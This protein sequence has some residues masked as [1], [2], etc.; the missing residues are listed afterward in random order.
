MHDTLLPAIKGYIDVLPTQNISKIACGW[1]LNIDSDTPLKMRAIDNDK[2]IPIEYK[3]RPDVASFYKVADHLPVGWSISYDKHTA[4]TLQAWVGEQWQSVFYL[5][6]TNIERNELKEQVQSW[7]VFDTLL[8]RK[9]PHPTDIFSIIETNYPYASF[10]HLRMA[11]ERQS[12]GTIADIYLQFQKLTGE[13][14][15]CIE[16]LRRFELQTEKEMT[17]PIQTNIQKIK[18]GDILVSDMYFTDTE[19]LDLLKHHGIVKFRKLYVFMCGKQNGSAW[20]QLTKLYTITQHTGDNHHSDIHMAERYGIK[21]I[22]TEAYK[23]SQLETALLPIDP[24]LCSLVRRFRLACPYSEQS[25]EASLYYEQINCNIP[26]LIFLCR[27]LAAI[28]MT[29]NRTTALFL[30]RDGVLMIQLF[31]LLYPQFKALPLHSSRIMN[32]KYNDDYIKYLREMYN[33][34]TCILFDLH[35][36][37]NSG[38]NMFMK[39]FGHLPRIFIFIND[40][41]APTF[42]KLTYIMSGRFDTIEAM[43]TDLVGT[44]CNFIGTRDI[45]MPP[46]YNMSFVRINHSTFKMFCEFL[47]EEKAISF[48]KE[49]PLFDDTDFWIKYFLSAIQKV[50]TFSNLRDPQTLTSFANHYQSDKGNTYKCAH[51]YTLKY[52][53]IIDTLVNRQG[54]ERPRLLE[55]GLNRDRVNTIPSLM[56]WNDYFN[57][58]VD[59]T[60]FDIESFFLKFN[61]HYDNIRIVIGDQANTHDLKQLQDQKYHLIIDD[62]YHASK[63]QQITFKTLWNN[64]ESGGFFII[65]DLHYQP[66]PE[67]PTCV[68]TRTMFDAWAEGNYITTE[69]ISADEIIDIMKT[70]K[71]IDF[72][73]SQSKR[74]ENPQHAM[75]ILQ[76]S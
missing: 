64:V 33:H 20:E 8:A 43:N 57:K 21:G 2:E 69:W 40:H 49:N 47:Q 7:D 72:Y 63:H 44:L 14:Q 23:F 26:I 55:I 70:L 10:K 52:E 24:K 35:G 37:L 16:S 60:G 34:D 1:C 6:Y 27:K 46:E 42:E 22:Y 19:I 32:K 51:H 15:E 71:S 13:T 75:V 65:E 28:M 56:I 9:V 39:C 67:P 11:A 36:S 38:R 25:T 41:R 74:W 29:E 68:K 17:I 61:G 76:K 73:D 59:I 31:R 12:N 45:R 62:G 4:I 3:P 30:T 58:H 50:F 53:E 48:L 5:F 18:P 66:E 54:I